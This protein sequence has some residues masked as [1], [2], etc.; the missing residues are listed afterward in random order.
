MAAT[1]PPTGGADT[2]APTTEQIP[3]SQRP[4]IGA[5]ATFEPA[6][7]PS[8][9]PFR[10]HATDEELAD[11]KRRIAA[12]RWPGQELV[13]DAS[14]GVQLA[15][16]RK[17]AE[18]HHAFAAAAQSHNAESLR[19]YILDLSAEGQSLADYYQALSTTKSAK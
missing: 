16:I 19:Q 11:L 1:T 10:F 3:T 2:L 13:G 15:T 8:I 17:L 9:R 4:V 14:Q 12:T 5:A 18:T 7:D 6:D